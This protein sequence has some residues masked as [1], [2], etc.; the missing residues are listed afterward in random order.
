MSS[1]P[2]PL[3]VTSQSKSLSAFEGDPVVA[4]ESLSI[5][6]SSGDEFIETGK[7]SNVLG[8]PIAA[9]VHLVSVLEKQPDHAPLKAGEIISTGTITTAHSVD[10]GQTWRSEFKGGEFAGLTIEFVP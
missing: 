1:A 10:V 6:L 5:D 4:I 9:I 8:N 2:T 7:G 3:F